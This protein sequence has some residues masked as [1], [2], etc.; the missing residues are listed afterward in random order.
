[1]FKAITLISIASIAFLNTVSAAGAVDGTVCNFNTDCSSAHCGWDRKCYTPEVKVK[2]NDGAS[3]LLN[4]DCNSGHCSWGRV[5]YTKSVVLAAEME[6][7]APCVESSG[8]S[9]MVLAL[10]AVASA[11]L[12][13]YLESI[14]MKVKSQLQEGFL[15]DVEYEKLNVNTAAA[16]HQRC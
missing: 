5:C 7:Q 16:V 12:G 3:C 10:V 4:S 2:L 6:G 8:Y 13:A 9:F 14:R 1:M 11:M 15:S